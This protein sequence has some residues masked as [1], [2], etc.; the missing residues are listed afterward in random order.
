MARI[1]RLLKNKK[2]MMFP[3]AI[4]L[5]VSI[6]IIICAVSEYIR[7]VI[8]ASG[9]RDAMQQAIV[10]VIN[11]NYDDVYHGV[12]E[13]YAGG[14]MPN[15]ASWDESIDYSD[16]YGYMDNILGSSSFGGEHIKY[17]GEDIEYKFYGLSVNI[18]NT[19]FA[20]DSPN[21]NEKY[22]ADAELKLE[23]PVSFIGNKFPPMKINLKLKAGYMAKF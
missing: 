23:V 21:T 14:Y 2:G 7:L 11:D 17:A 15:S 16:V 5:T 13:G 4:S 8:I 12:R 18:E 1:Y 22:T 10:S 3:L 9:V 19:T 6:L 20:P